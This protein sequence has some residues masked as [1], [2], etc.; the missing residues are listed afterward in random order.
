MDSTGQKRI[1]A[2]QNLYVLR[3]EEVRNPPFR[4]VNDVSRDLKTAGGPK[5]PS[6]LI[7]SGS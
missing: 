1:K 2:N 4:G 7:S 5:G 3:P 6:V